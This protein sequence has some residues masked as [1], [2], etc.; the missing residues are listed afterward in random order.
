[1]IKRITKN[2]KTAIVE[3]EEKEVKLPVEEERVKLREQA[4]RYNRSGEIL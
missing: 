1:M 2:K 3:E 4:I